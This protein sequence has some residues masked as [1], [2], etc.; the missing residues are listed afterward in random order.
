MSRLSGK[1]KALGDLTPHSYDDVVAACGQPKEKAPLSLPGGGEGTRAVWRDGVFALTLDFDAEGNGLGIYRRRSREPYL[2]LG[3]VLLAVAAAALTVGAVTRARAAD[4]ELDAEGVTARLV[5]STDIWK[6]DGTAGICL[7]DLDFDGTPELLVTDSEFVWDDELAADYFGP[8]DVA[9]YT[10][11]GGGLTAAGTFTTD[12]YC[13]AATVHRYTDA[14]G[15]TGWYCP[16]ED[17]VLLLTLSDGSLQISGPV[18]GVDTAG[19][20]EALRLLR[21][22]AWVSPSGAA[23]SA[24]T[25]QADIAAVAEDYFANN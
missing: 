14:L 21:N 6:S 22:E 1:I 9:V 4:S 5:R 20:D 7:A 17:G 3:A 23:V 8:S 13:F 11:A 2:W 16:T 12:E 24:E 15:K 18:S 10:L 25:V 19:G